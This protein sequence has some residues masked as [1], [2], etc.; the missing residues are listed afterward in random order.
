M[1]A[2]VA[3]SLF[4]LAGVALVV[5]VLAGYTWRAAAT[6]EQASR[7]AVAALQ[8]ADV[9]RVLGER[10]ADA[11]IAARPDLISG[12]ALISAG[13]GAAVGTE[14]FATLV[15]EAVRDL[16]GAVFERREDTLAL[17][18]VDV[19]IVAGAGLQAVDPELARRLEDA[20][21]VTLWRERSSAVE[22]A[23]ATAR[24]VRAVAVAAALLALAAVVAAC[25]ALRSRPRAAA[26]S[27]G[28]T[29][30]GAGLGVVVLQLFGGALVTRQVAGED[31]RTA[32]AALWDAFFAD[33][34]GVG[35]ALMATGGIVVAVA[36]ARVRAP[37]I[38][39][40]VRRAWAAVRSEPSSRA[41]RVLR[42][43][44]LV[45]LG[46][47]LFAEPATAAALGVRLAGLYLAYRGLEA[48]MRALAPEV[49]AEPAG[50][51]ARRRPR[52]VARLLLPALA[53]AAALALAVAVFRPDHAVSGPVVTPA[54][55][56]G[57]V[58]LCSRSLREIA[59]P[60]THNAMSVPA[61]G[62]SAALQDRPIS[63]Q[64]EDGVRG[65]L[66]DTHYGERLR[67]GQVRTVFDSPADLTASLR[68]DP[69]QQGALAAARRLRARLGFRGAGER[70]LYLCHSFCELGATPLADMLADVHS[71]LVM[72]PADVLVVVNQDHIT[73][74]DFVA[75]VKE[76]GLDRFAFTP[77]AG[78]D[79][80]TLREM[81]DSDRRLVVLA[82]NEAGGAPWYQLAYERLLEETPF[83]FSAPADLVDPDRLAASCR[84]ERGPEGAPLFLLN[85]WIN[86]DPTP[87]PSNARLVNTRAALLARARAC[88]R[89]RSRRTLN[90]VAVDFY[91]QG[92][93]FGAVDEL[94]GL[95]P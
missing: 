31:A 41:L 44:G 54:G 84:A 11:L 95:P 89:E 4:T 45:A 25:V 23:A 55:C 7:R 43:A 37:A 81:I 49:P 22:V 10:A 80:P 93:V 68:D 72:H 85:H 74:A 51:V 62:W 2:L 61:P 58:E 6:S 5:A 38:E 36:T 87:R 30:V 82:E 83:S 50:N 78:D 21:R 71:F 18:L 46:I 76:A 32:A 13:V 47:A 59:L 52:R 79:W 14:A 9:R 42:G 39:D 27:L 48:L 53:G 24:V 28:W 12:R 90:L 20:R 75:A 19:G 73:P 34:R 86:T 67:G 91:K 60:A 17:T 88:E 94:N 40:P 26:T 66:V 63:G 64:L 77:P 29:L 56:N 3:R 70:G 65:L 35:W 15:R 1:R 33:L 8:D 16:H 57:H 69:A 92:D